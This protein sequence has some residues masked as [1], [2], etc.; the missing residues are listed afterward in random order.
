MREMKKKSIAAVLTAVM[1]SMGLTGCGENVIPDMTEEQVKSVGEYV[2]FTLMKY[3]AN[4]RSRLVDLEELEEQAA[5]QPATP[6]PEPTKAPEGMGATDNTPVIDSASPVNS[7][8]MEEV[9]GLPSGIAV[10]YVGQSVCESYPE[11][12]GYDFFSLDASEG[13]KLLVLSFELTNHSEQEQE[14]NLLTSGTVFRVTVNGEY[15]RRALTTML[16]NDMSTFVGTVPAG[17]STEAVILIEMDAERAADI[18]S[19]SFDL[20][21]DVK[22]YTIQLL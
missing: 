19:V 14:I 7:C 17:G 21:N 2:A 5:I 16:I 12:G 9:M 8:T 6:E 10:S 3:D 15:T 13:K 22:T 4:H 1:L 18:S 11:D 20:K